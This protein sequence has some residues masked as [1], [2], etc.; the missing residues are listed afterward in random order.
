MEPKETVGQRTQPARKKQ[1]GASAQPNKPAGNRHPTH[2]NQ[3]QHMNQAQLI[4]SVADIAAA[5]RRDVEHRAKGP[6]ACGRSRLSAE[7]GA[8]DEE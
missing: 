1:R 3:E 7:L 4:A 6:A 2:P 5:P 8:E